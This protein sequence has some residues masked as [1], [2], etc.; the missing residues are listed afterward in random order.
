MQKFFFH[1]LD[2]QCCSSIKTLCK[3]VSHC[4][5]YFYYAC[6]FNSLC[7]CVCTKSQEAHQVNPMHPVTQLQNTPALTSGIWGTSTTWRPC[8]CFG[9]C[10]EMD[11]FWKHNGELAQRWTVCTLGRQSGWTS[12]ITLLLYHWRG[13]PVIC[14]YIQS[15]CL[16]RQELQGLWTF[17]FGAILCLTTT[18][19]DYPNYMFSML[20]Y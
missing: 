10:G 20:L 3:V 2:L 16:L 11:T 4:N 18:V 19:H 8:C 17:I 12:C 13:P 15:T 7:M 9:T 1:H 5:E 14:V 6:T